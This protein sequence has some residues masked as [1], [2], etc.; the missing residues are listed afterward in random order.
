MG[1]AEGPGEKLVGQ[2]QQPGGQRWGYRMQTAVIA[3]CLLLL[4]CGMVAAQ[5][6]SLSLAHPP[7]PDAERLLAA[8][9]AQDTA[10]GLLRPL[11]DGWGRLRAQLIDHGI[12]PAF[13][14]NGAGF[15]DLTGGLRQGATYLGTAH[16]QLTMDL[17]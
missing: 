14:Y 5:V 13:I 12:Q 2:P 7:A 8:A 3:V 1:S 9:P 6:S 4:W 10:P 15:A 11:I 16:L 17:S